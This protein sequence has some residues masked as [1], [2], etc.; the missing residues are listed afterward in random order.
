MD[1]LAATS[2]LGPGAA[3]PSPRYPGAAGTRVP[4]EGAASLAPVLLGL[5]SVHRRPCAVTTMSTA[6]RQGSSV[7]QRRAPVK[8]E[9]STCP[10]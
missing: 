9:P 4:A 10:G 3:V 7:T 6:A 5:F 8:W 2:S 1:T